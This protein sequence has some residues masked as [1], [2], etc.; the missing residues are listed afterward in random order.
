MVQAL[1]ILAQ[2]FVMF[3]FTGCD[4][5]LRTPTGS[6]SLKLQVMNVELAST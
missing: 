1:T 2:N 5:T 3:S 6:L 4:M